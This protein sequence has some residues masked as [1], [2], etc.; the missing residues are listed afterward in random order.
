MD[1]AEPR[2]F[3]VEEEFLLVDG[4]TGLPV[5]AS[6]A[7]LSADAAH[8]THQDGPKLT[9]ELQQEMLEVVGPPHHTLA[10]LQ[11]DVVTGRALVDQA[12][13]AA[14][15]RAAALATSPR[16]T[17][18]HGHPGPRYDAIMARYGISA[19]DSLACGMHVHV[20]VAS[21]EEGVGVLDRIRTWLPVLLALSANSPFVRGQDT[22]YASYRYQVWQ[23]WPSAGPSPVFGSVAAYR[24]ME[25]ELL[26]TRVLLDEGML[27]FD[28]RL[29]RSH[30][31]VEVRIA[32]VCLF[33]EDAGLVA[34][35]VR[36][37]VETAARDWRAGTVPPQASVAAL[38]LASW[39]AGLSGLGGEL[40]H[41]VTGRPAAARDVV[42]T[43]FEHVLA[44]LAD[45]GDD[46]AVAHKLARLLD[47][48]SGA[49]RQRSVHRRTGRLSDVVLDAVQATHSPDPGR[50]G[51]LA[52]GVGP[53]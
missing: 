32:D 2:L 7:A 30:P 41:P 18:P 5:S 12:A 40:V 9:A 49:D 10:G 1:T 6:C 37:L 43:L 22:D 17:Q 24:A 8:A 52:A 15:A 29:S 21:P 46:E 25:R 31:T 48:G 16:S 4:V 36:G 39:R 35:L 42:A 34:A 11:E 47:R 38:R 27:Y 19:R 53:A 20:A 50:N 23:T 26:D 33:P 3:G 45:A 13:R 44:A 51:M 14:G 28:A